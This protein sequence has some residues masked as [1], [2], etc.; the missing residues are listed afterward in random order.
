MT[1]QELIDLLTECNPDSEVLLASQSHYPLEHELR[2]LT[3]RREM[4]RAESEDEGGDDDVD[5]DEDSDMDEVIL[6]DGAFR[7]YGSKTA[8]R[9]AVRG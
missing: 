8:W 7:G 6:V 4:V 1:V 5:N 9:V 2:G 3:T